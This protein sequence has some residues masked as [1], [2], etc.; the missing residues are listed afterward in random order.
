M[1]IEFVR[2]TLRNQ[3]GLA[4]FLLIT[5]LVLVYAPVRDYPFINYDDNLYVTEASQVQQG[6]GWDSVVWAMTTMEA[7]FWHP[8]TSLS[9]IL[10]YQLFG[11]NPT[12]HHLTNLL[13]HLVNVVLL[14]WVLHR[15]TGALWPSAL[16]AALFSLHPLNV[17]SVAW[18]AER[19]NVLSTL[20]WLLTLLAYVG[21][22]KKP[23]WK[24]YLGMMGIFVLGLMAK[25]M[26]VTLPCVLL[27]LD[28]WPLGRL[29]NDSKTFW[30]RLPKLA[31]EKLPLFAP[32]AVASILAI[33]AQSQAGALSSWEGLPLGTR[34]G[35][36][37]LAYGLYLKKMVWPTDLAVFYPHPGSSLEAWP[38]ALAALLLVGL[39][40]GVW[41]QGR[42]SPYLVVGWLWYLGTLFPVSGVIQVGEHAMADRYA[43]VPLM[44]LFIILV[45]GTAELSQTLRFP[46][47]WLLASGLCLLVTLALLTRVQLG[48]WQSTRALFEHA[49]TVTSNNH[50]AH[51]AVGIELMEEKQLGKAVDHLTQAL[52]INPTYADAHNNLGL[53]FSRQGR[54]EEGIRHYQQALQI[55]PDSYAAHNNLGLVILGSGQVDE[56]MEHF[57]QAL[58]LNP[59]Y[60]EA[61]NNLGTAMLKKGDRAKAMELFRKALELRP[62]FAEAHYNLGTEL[63][64]A[65]EF[66]DAKVHFLAAVQANPAYSDAYVNLGVLLKREG[67][68]NEAIDSY[69]K[70]LQLNPN[71][72]EAHNNLGTALAQA[73]DFQQAFHHFRE[74]VTIN[75]NYREAQEN[76]N[77]L[78]SR[79]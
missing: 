27:L 55:R 61:Y 79:E 38:V 41:W 66:S 12:G 71:H 11:L 74:A 72:A 57:S 50:V 32:V 10:D 2:L 21:Y 25:P 78:S 39:S 64:K 15:M 23:D 49:L 65:A 18:V 62:G 28:Y 47:T 63:L 6:L 70:A 60:V 43:Y 35:N 68:V 42:R 30:K 75:P 3:K 36:A 26:L 46:K 17:E 14:F 5:S 22:V 9:H 31:L 58:L 37:V 1:D 8:L 44:G 76:L 73:G 59:S 33:E 34:V 69:L 19:K 29:G 24:R 56:A 67:R 7:A 51:N 13:L 48:Y 52:A 77:R 53:A 45:W 4:I 40:L 54:S 20:F 16:V